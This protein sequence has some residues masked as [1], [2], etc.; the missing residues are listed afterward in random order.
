MTGFKELVAIVLVGCLINVGFP[1][2]AQ[3]MAA[4]ERGDEF[5]Q[6]VEQLG[7][8]AE[9]RVTRRDQQRAL[10]GTVE[11]FDDSAF[12]LRPGGTGEPTAVRYV[13]VTMLQFTKRKYR[14][15]GS[16]TPDPVTARRVAVELGVGSKVRVE[17]HDGKT[18]VGKIVKV[19]EKQLNLDPGTNGPMSVSY[20]QMRELKPK[21]MSLT[22][23]IG[24]PAAV[25]GVLLV[26]GIATCASGG[27]A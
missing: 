8:G 2:Q 7:A 24:I 16:N 9:V 26:V 19:D 14:A 15:E 10:R 12:R 22:A 27:C 6:K 18:V 11:S 17:T 3:A 5:R 1:Q 25:F 20:A 23:K 21:G 4:A 13:D